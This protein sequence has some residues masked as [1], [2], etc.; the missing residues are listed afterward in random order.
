MRTPD[1]NIQGVT[2]NYPSFTNDLRHTPIWSRG[3]AIARLLALTGVDY[4]YLTLAELSGAT[5]LSR[6][7]LI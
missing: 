1:L 3:A 7:E 6:W 5:G 2:H 4:E